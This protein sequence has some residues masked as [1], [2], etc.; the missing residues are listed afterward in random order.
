MH[1]ER[2]HLVLQEK[3]KLLRRTS[4]CWLEIGKVQAE[5][6]WERWDGDKVY[7]PPVPALKELVSIPGLLLLPFHLNVG[8]I[9][10]VL[11]HALS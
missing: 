6:N 9:M 8:M 5:E 3:D 1:R 4:V 2:L 10:W 7:Y 11:Q